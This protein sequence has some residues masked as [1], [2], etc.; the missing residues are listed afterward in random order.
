VSRRPT[1][2]EGRS[3]IR[4]EGAPAPLGP[5]S[6]ARMVDGILYVA[7]QGPLDVGGRVRGDT[8]EEQARA[9]LD[10]L[11]AIV[12]AAGGNLSDV[13]KVNV[14]LADMSDWPPFNDVYREYFQKPFPART[15]VQAGLR[16]I[17]V[18]VDAIAHLP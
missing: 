17:M 7:G 2:P 1:P 6:Q 5:Y 4:S 16:G 8:L 14:Y 3:E 13:V 12:E 9:T 15:A 10:N 11:K 18:E